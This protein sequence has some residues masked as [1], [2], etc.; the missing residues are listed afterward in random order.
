MPVQLLMLAGLAAFVIVAFGPQLLAAGDSSAASHL[1]QL[2][3]QR[4]QAAGRRRRIIF[5][6]DGNSIAYAL[7]EVSAEALLADRTK[8]LLGTHVDS[9]FYCTWS[10]GLALF[11]HK[12]ALAEPFVATTGVFKA[13]LTKQFRDRGLDPLQIMVE[14]CR[15]NGI[16]FFWSMRMN[17]IHDAFPQWP[18]MISQFK[19]DH[20]QLLFGTPE[21]PPPF[22]MW[23]GLDYGEPE[24]RERA[25]RLLEDVCERYDVD[26]VEM[27]FMRH[28]PHFR[29]NAK[30]EDCTQKERD[31]MTGLARRVREMTERVGLARGRP[32]LVAVRIPGSV[33]CCEAAGLDVTR[34]LEEDLVDV[35]VPGEWELSPW[36]DWVAL[37]RRHGAPVYPCLS[38]SPSRKRQGPP[39]ARHGR[40]LTGYRARAM[41]V[42]HSGSDGVYTFNLFDPTSSAWRELG[43]PKVLAGLD[44]DYFPAYARPL[45]GR[46]MRDLH[47]FVELPST[48]CPERPVTLEADRP[49][50]VTMTIGE[51]PSGCGDSP[52][53][54]PRATLSLLV[55]GLTGADALV[56]SLNGHAVANGSFAEDWR[57]YTVA[58]EWVRSGANTVEMTHSDRSGRAVVL[59]DVHV[60]IAYPRA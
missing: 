49:H 34:W 36:E 26:G 43:E 4:R 56:V 24:V 44:K 9:I 59:S 7:K 46:D 53:S 60:R 1:G 21:E 39:H 58:A 29:C 19:K 23:S 12:S 8:G 41:N 6:N 25:F 5:N 37:G 32:L 51:D 52:K 28:V 17:D 2:R 11:T 50:A 10:A 30:G 13:N 55:T 54:R 27:D 16:E 45:R 14:F 33:P 47:R 40:P 42:W 35:L 22:G 57:T 48:L 31:I 38:W 20:P 3:R 18:E 15:A